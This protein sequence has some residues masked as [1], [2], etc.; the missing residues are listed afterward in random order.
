MLITLCTAGSIN[1]HRLPMFVAIGRHNHFNFLNGVSYSIGKG[2][3]EG[4]RA[5]KKI[6]A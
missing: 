3:G 5:I 2:E 6:L 1:G 4:K